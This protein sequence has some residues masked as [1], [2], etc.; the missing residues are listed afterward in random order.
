M[1]RFISF[2]DGRKGYGAFNAMTEAEYH[3]ASQD[4]LDV[5]DEHEWVWQFADN[6]A[7]AIAQHSD[8]HDEWYAAVNSN[9]EKDTY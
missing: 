6:H 3:A 5:V 2:E 1:T 8:K 9:T 7:Q 4:V